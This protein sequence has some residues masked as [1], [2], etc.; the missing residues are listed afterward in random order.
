MIMMITVGFSFVIFIV[1][2]GIGV[3]FYSG[4]NVKAT[5]EQRDPVVRWT[6]R[7]PLPVLAISLWLALGVV[8]IVTTAVA[9]MA[10][11]PLFG[12]LVAGLPALVICAVMAAVW[13]WAAWAIFRLDER[14]LWVAIA[15]TILFSVSSIL[16][17]SRHELSE[18]YRLAGYPASQ[19][20]VMERTP[21]PGWMMT[22]GTLFWVVPAV[23]FLLY[24]RR[25][26]RKEALQE[27]K[28]G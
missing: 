21:L 10:V 24:S 17:Y 23:G 16:T 4:K 6:D 3:I 1:V 26:F 19:V 27:P 14:G 8:G 15:F 25:Y 13:A 12:S 20:A 22:W 2:P 28:I 11:I 7:R 5:C 18:M 9:G